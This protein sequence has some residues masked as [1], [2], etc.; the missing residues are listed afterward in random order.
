[1]RITKSI[2]YSSPTSPNAERLGFKTQGCYHI[3]QTLMNIEDSGQCRTSIPH[4]AEGYTDKLDSDLI[5][6]F[7]E[8]EGDVCPMFLKY[9]DT[10]LL[11]AIS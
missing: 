1:M 8:T 3:E 5:A 4:N 6:Q 11:K 7:H 10:E 9:G 2:S